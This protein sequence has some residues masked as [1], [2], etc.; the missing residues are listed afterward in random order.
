MNYTVLCF[1]YTLCALHHTAFSDRIVSLGSAVTEIVVALDADDQLVGVDDSSLFPEIPQEVPT[2]GYY[3][4]VSA[5][6]I[7]SVRPNLILSTEDAGP[8]EAIQ[9]IK[10]SRVPFVQVT[11]EK[12]LQATAERIRTLGE[13]LHKEEAAEELLVPIENRI[14]HPLPPLDPAPRVLFIFARGG[15]SPS[16]SGK[17]TGADYMIQLAGAQNAVT[18]FKGYRPLT[19]EGLIISQPD[20][21]LITQEGLEAM[22][23]EKALWALPGMANTP[24]GTHKRCV[25]ME[26]VFLLGFGPNVVEAADYLRNGLEL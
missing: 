4:M 19:A 2:V 12:S 6:G 11:A 9:K 18:A 22:G 1:I 14:A 8:P 16:V 24:A 15:G 26:T 25:V 13:T 17:G 3:R 20:V 23:G 10:N 5:E 7:L 21:I